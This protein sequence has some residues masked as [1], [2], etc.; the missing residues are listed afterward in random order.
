MLHKLRRQ[1]KQ[2]AEFMNNPE[3]KQKVIAGEMD[4][5][6]VAKQMQTT[7]QKKPPA[8][9]RSPNGVNGQIKSPIM[10]MSSKQFKELV[11]RVKKGERFRE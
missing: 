4:F 2:T 9:M 10:S 6:D 11:D 5:W 8:P 3:I 1:P 7:P